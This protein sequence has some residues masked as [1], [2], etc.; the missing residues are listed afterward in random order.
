MDDQTW[1]AART[2]VTM[3]AEAEAF[4]ARMKHRVAQGRDW[5]ANWEPRPCPKEWQ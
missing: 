2:T 1:G 3:E 4:I 5:I